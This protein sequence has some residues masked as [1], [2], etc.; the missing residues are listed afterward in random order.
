A[1]AADTQRRSAARSAC[2][3]HDR[4]GALAKRLPEHLLERRGRPHVG[5]G[6][7]HG[8]SCLPGLVAGSYQRRTCSF[9]DHGP[10]RLR[11]GVLSLGVDGWWGAVALDVPDVIGRVSRLQADRV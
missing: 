3:S 7:V 2:S 9:V 1:I 4:G 8:G 11:I 5:A 10:I 6:A